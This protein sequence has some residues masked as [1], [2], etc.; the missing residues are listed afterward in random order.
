MTESGK[1]IPGDFILL[2]RQEVPRDT[3]PETELGTQI[4]LN[5]MIDQAVR[6][7]QAFADTEP[8]DDP[9]GFTAHCNACKAAV[10]HLEQLYRFS[11]VLAAKE[12]DEPSGGENAEI[13]E[14]LIAEARASLPEL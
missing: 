2:D 7:Y 1:I 13:L 9:R 3:S 12:H 4:N 6:R 10:A 11:K 14:V 8:P 5:R